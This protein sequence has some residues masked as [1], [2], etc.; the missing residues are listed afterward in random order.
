MVPKRFVTAAAP[1]SCFFVTGC[2]NILINKRDMHYVIFHV[3]TPPGYVKFSRNSQ[4]R[5]PVTRTNAAHWRHPP[6]KFPADCLQFV[7][8]L[9]KNTKNCTRFNGGMRPA[10]KL[11]LQFVTQPDDRHKKARQFARLFYEEITL[12][13]TPEMPVHVIQ[14]PQHT[15]HH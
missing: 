7:I 1:T 5:Q 10:D 3:T 14:H 11:R 13:F 2:T 6:E 4:N 9:Y 15:G 8:N 12:L